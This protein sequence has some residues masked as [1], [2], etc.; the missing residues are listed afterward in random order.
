MQ[1]NIPKSAFSGLYTENGQPIL[2]Y[3]YA[4]KLRSDVMAYVRSKTQPK[5]YVDQNGGQ[6]DMLSA[7]VD[8]LIGGGSRGGGKGEPYSAPIITPFGIRR[9]GDLKVGSII[10]DIHGGMQ[11]VIKITELGKRKVFRLHFS[12]GTFVDCTDDHIWKIKQTCHIHKKRILNGTDQEADWRLW[13]MKM[14]MEH[15]DR[16]K[17]GELRSKQKS[18]L[19]VPLCSPVKFTKNLKYRIKT[20]PYIFGVVLGD[21]CI[22]KAV[23]DN[24]VTARLTTADNELILAFTKA[25]LYVSP[26]RRKQTSRLAYDYDIKSESLE[27]DLQAFSLNYADSYTKFIPDDILYAPLKVRLAVIQ[28]LMDTDGTI[29][30][31]GHCSY[32]TIS[33]KIADGMAFMLRSLGAYVTVSKKKAGYKKDGRH[34]RCSDVYELYIKY[35]DTSSLFRLSKKKERCSVCNA[36]ASETTKRITGYEYIGDDTCRCIVVSDPSALYLTNDFTVTH[37]SWSMLMEALYDINKPGFQALL[38]RKETKDLDSLQSDAYKLYSDFGDYNKSI[39]DMTWNF[40]AG[41][42]LKFSYYAGNYQSFKD[43]F[44]GRQYAYIGIDEITQCEY[45]KFKYL[46][47]VNRNGS[48]IRTR[49]WG[50]CNPDPDSWV[51]KFIDW[52]IDEDGYAIPERCGKVRYCYMDGN[53]PDSIYW[54][55]T[56]EE[57]YEQCSAVIDSVWNDKL[58]KTYSKI[59]LTKLDVIIKSVTF[60]RADITGNEVLTTS[61]PAYVGTLAGQ[62]E[63]QRMRDLHANWNWKATGDDMIKYEDMDAFFRNP[64]QIGDGIRRASADIAFVGGDNFVMWLVVGNHVKDLIVMRLD[65]KTVI[66]VVSTKLREWGVEE[67]NFT[68]DMQGIGQ[69]FKGFFPDALPFNNQMSPIALN[70]EEKDG[71]KYLYKDLKSQA[72]WLFYQ[73]IKELNI[74][75]DRG[76]LERKYSGDGF[77]NWT[78][79]RIL[80]KER[81]AI[82]RDENGDD[83]GFRILTKKIAKKYV[84]HSPDFIESLYYWEYPAKL[85]KKR[86]TKAKGLWMF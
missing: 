36:G 38:L 4:Q 82:R 86:H 39:N 34:L 5:L 73:D 21:G 1:E 59:G 19:L 79:E 24:H 31:R 43:R 7:D 37:N 3:E 14:I 9:M 54:G 12:D 20:D 22:T 64:V 35:R 74:S 2:T 83:K 25:G 80:Q 67:K 42:W 70:K 69:Y 49:F 29:D 16:Q 13:T 71:I 72:A 81:K 50:T 32:N 18:N 60:V 84:G 52:W 85:T 66:S 40:N 51:R 17:R 33:P 77:K 57:V 56:R 15:L 53:S 26:P 76:L 41:G 63:E 68:Y 65:P 58:E 30:K 75:I 78:L 6:E 8:I 55:S 45:K 10:T 23:K 27:Q 48:G 61:D 46:T 47:T 62:D 44:Q 28:G 11:R